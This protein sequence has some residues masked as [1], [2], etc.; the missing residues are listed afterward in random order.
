LTFQ[1]ATENATF[2]TIISFFMYLHT[3]R[4]Y[5]SLTIGVHL[6]KNSNDYSFIVSMNRILD[7]NACESSV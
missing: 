3:S 5:I 1:D 7:E 4:N 6:L 2:I